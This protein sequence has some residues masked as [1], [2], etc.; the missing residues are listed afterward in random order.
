MSHY[1]VLVIGDNPEEQ[2]A[3]FDENS[4]VE[5]YA[6]DVVDEEDKR[7]FLEFYKKKEA[8]KDLPEGEPT[9]NVSFDIEEF[10]QYYAKY[11]DDWNSNNWRIDSEGVWQ[12]YSTYNPESKWDWYQLGGRWVNSFK[13]KEGA[14]GLTGSPSLISAEKVEA[15]YADRARKDAIDWEGMR[16][17]AFE[18]AAKRYNAFEEMVEDREHEKAISLAE[19]MSARWNLNLYPNEKYPTKPQDDYSSEREFVEAM[20]RDKCAITFGIIELLGKQRTIPTREKYLSD[21]IP[22]STYAVLKEGEWHAPGRMLMFGQSTESEQ[23][24]DEFHSKFFETW[25][26]PLPEDTLL[27]VYDCHI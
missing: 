17:E 26:E 15:G 23:E 27:S 12:E 21:I 10:A 19:H 18:N 2:L 11:G 6:R 7:N 16:L 24:S 4:E 5:E 22:F 20:W 25:I 9:P 13:L 1:T 8:A 3:P 14:K